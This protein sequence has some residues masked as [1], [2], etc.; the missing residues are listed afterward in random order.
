MSD[1]D[2]DKPQSDTI[3]R[4]KLRAEIERCRRIIE[5]PWGLRSSNERGPHRDDSLLW[6]RVR[7][8]EAI[9]DEPCAHRKRYTIPSGDVVCL[10]CPARDLEA[11]ESTEIRK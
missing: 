3:H 1:Q 2:E 5:T 9:L 6:E 4:D 11:N 8:L 10:R 7:C